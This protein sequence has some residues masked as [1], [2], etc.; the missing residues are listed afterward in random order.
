MNVSA[1][2]FVGVYLDVFGQVDEVGD[3]SHLDEQTRNKIEKE[4]E[5]FSSELDVN[6][7]GHLDKVRLLWQWMLFILSLCYRHM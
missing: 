5:R 6:K 7:D 3:E 4:M 2:F 1:L